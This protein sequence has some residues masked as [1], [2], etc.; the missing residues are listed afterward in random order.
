MSQRLHFCYDIFCRVLYNRVAAA[1]SPHIG[2]NL[3]ATTSDSREPLY[4]PCIINMPIYGTG[5][6][7]FLHWLLK[8][9]QIC[10]AL[11]F[12]LKNVL[13][14][15]T[16]RQGLCLTNVTILTYDAVLLQVSIVYGA[17][18]ILGHVV[19]TVC[20]QPVLGEAQESWHGRMFPH[21]TLVFLKTGLGS[22]L[23][24]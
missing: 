1:W 23:I 17:I 20:I 8:I 4:A 13:Y 24:T 15:P 9:W 3:M 5:I 12:R 18:A 11:N 7:L 14:L 16:L 2:S 6:T 19:G 21:H 22:W 10:N